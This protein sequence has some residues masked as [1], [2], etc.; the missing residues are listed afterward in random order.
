MDVLH[1]EGLIARVGENLAQSRHR[2]I[3][4]GAD[5]G[6]PTASDRFD[7]RV[8]T[9]PFRAVDCVIAE[10]GT[11]PTAETVEGHWDGNRD[12]DADHAGLDTP[13]KVAGGV[14][15]AGED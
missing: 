7:T 5:P 10:E 14:A 3:D 9:Y 15:V 2:G 11:L 13:R 6:R 4:S 1:N 12:V 8:K